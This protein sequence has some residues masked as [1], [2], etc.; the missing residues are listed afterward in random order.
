MQLRKY[1][2]L[3]GLT[4][5]QVAEKMGFS[6]VATVGRHET[7]VR[8]PSLADIEKY[9]ILTEGAVRIDDW[10]ALQRDPDLGKAA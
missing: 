3:K 6:S 9:E 5:E 4:L 8:S 7:G 2:K 1:R 10:R